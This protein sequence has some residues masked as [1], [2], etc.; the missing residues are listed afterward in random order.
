MTSPESSPLARPVR[1]WAWNAMVLPQELPEIHIGSPA[2]F[3]RSTTQESHELKLTWPPGSRTVLQALH[4]HKRPL[5]RPAGEE[6][7]ALTHARRLH[8]LLTILAAL[9]TPVLGRTGPMAQPLYPN[10]VFEVGRSPTGL[11]AGDF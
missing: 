6:I 3:L 4:S 8:R 1:L 11:V 10:P 9:L 2:P 7:M 5:S